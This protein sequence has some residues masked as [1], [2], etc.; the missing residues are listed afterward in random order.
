M[1]G[2]STTPGAL[3]REGTART[4]PVGAPR[5]RPRVPRM[6]AGTRPNWSRIIKKAPRYG[7]GAEVGR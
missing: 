1:T 5:G 3:V 6:S 2:G 7:I 4:Y